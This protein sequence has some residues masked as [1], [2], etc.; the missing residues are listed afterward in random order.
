MPENIQLI[1]SYAALRSYSGEATEIYIT[2]SGI[3][4]QFHQD[5]TDTTSL[6][7][8]GTII[9][10]ALAR[11]WKRRNASR[12]DVKWFG[13]IGDGV[14]DDSPAIQLALN[15]A[16]S[17][18]GGV[19]VLSWTSKS[20]AISNTILLPPNTTLICDAWLKI[21]A[22]T[23]GDCAVKGITGAGNWRVYNLRVD[24]NHIPAQGG[25]YLH[26]NHTGVYVDSVEVINAAHDPRGTGNG[27]LGGRACTIEAGVNPE[28]WGSRRSII[29]NVIAINCY[30]AVAIQGGVDA[31]SN[32][33][34]IG[35]VTAEYCEIVI[36]AFGNT[37]DYPHP[38][39]RMMGIINSVTARN[40]GVSKTYT[41]P[42]AVICSDRGSNVK[43]GSISVVNEDSYSSSGHGIRSLL[44]GDFNNF[45]IQSAYYE[46]NLAKSIIDFERFAEDHSISDDIFQTLGSKFNV[47]QRG[48]IATP[49][50]ATSK[51]LSRTK[52]Q[53][54]EFSADIEELGN[55]MID[56]NT[57]T[58][59]SFVLDVVTNKRIGGVSGPCTSIGSYDLQDFQPCRVPLGEMISRKVQSLIDAPTLAPG[60]SSPN[61]ITVVSGARIGDEATVSISINPQGVAI[62]AYV[63]DTDTVTW[64]FHNPTGNPAGTVDLGMANAQ[65]HVTPRRF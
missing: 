42:G 14:T 55:T 61:Y 41:R 31:E 49:H 22:D 29:G 62:M 12:I 10:D 43:I 54:T 53:A 37:R 32:N 63:S 45:E 17:I 9:V 64:Y 15:L 58:M 36:S 34:I 24:C 20:Y 8:G 39:T 21:L 44:W 65:I 60:A 59:P 7:N 26:R 4:G 48:S 28:S 40:C 52:I 33:F 5:G 11:R 50:L 13:A 23:S 35:N 27:T 2:S 3:E 6:D 56:A 38:A 57:R 1:T 25:L 18:G 51:S 46:G 19:V 47:K 30:N 16:R